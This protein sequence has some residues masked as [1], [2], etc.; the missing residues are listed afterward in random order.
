MKRQQMFVEE[1]LMQPGFQLNEQALHPSD[2]LEQSNEQLTAVI[3]KLK[4]ALFPGIQVQ[5][6]YAKVAAVIY[7]NPKAFNKKA[8]KGLSA[9]E[10]KAQEKVVHL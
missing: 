7:P 3:K 6:K 4:S 10:I 8:M 5:K 9:E 2:L 1:E